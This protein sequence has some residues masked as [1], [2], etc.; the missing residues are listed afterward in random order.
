M[1]TTPQEA[2]MK[3]NAFT[4]IKK[5]REEEEQHASAPRETIW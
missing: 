4:D 1:I 5:M 3:E 2:A